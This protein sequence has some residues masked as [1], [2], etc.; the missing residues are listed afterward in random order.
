MEKVNQPPLHTIKIEDIQQALPTPAPTPTKRSRENSCETSDSSSIRSTPR[1]RR[2]TSRYS[3]DDQPKR[4]RGRPP[5][6]EPEI[7]SLAE[8]R[9][10]SATDLR[11]KEMRIKNNESS[12]RS[13][14]NRKGKEG[15]IIDQLQF[16]E[17]R[18][19]D[20]QREN[21]QLELQVALWHKRVFKLATINCA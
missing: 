16:Q 14:A 10:L 18:F 21:E 8:R 20:L 7:L 1:K 2:T 13:R 17:K 3:E 15:L 19:H 11:H 5:K 12:R 4:P 9:R 6:T